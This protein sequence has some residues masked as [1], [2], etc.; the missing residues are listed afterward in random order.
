[1][2]YTHVLNRGKLA[3]RSLL[4]DKLSEKG[5]A[6]ANRLSISRIIVA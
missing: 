3:V 4:D 6:W 2:I 1:M 5:Q